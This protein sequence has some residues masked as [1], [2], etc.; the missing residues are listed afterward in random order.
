METHGAKVVHLCKFDSLKGIKYTWL[1]D[2]VESISQLIMKDAKQATE[3]AKFVIQYM[4]TVV[5]QKQKYKKAVSLPSGNH[6][7]STVHS[8]S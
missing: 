3:F 8:E 2:D 1:T 5:D 6:Q 7:P 4:N